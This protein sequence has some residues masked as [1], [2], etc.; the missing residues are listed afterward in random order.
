MGAGLTFNYN[1]SV[2]S[3][4]GGGGAV[5]QVTGSGAGISVT[6]STGNVVITNTGVTALTAGSGISLTASTGAV[7]ISA[8]GGGSGTVTQIIAA[9]PLTGGTISTV[10][11]I[12]LGT[13][14]VIPGPYTNAN[15]V[16]DAYGRITAA[17]NGTPGGGGTVTSVQTGTGLT[18]GPIFNSGTICLANTAVTPGA[19]NSA[20]ITIDQQGRI[21]SASSG[22][23][24]T[25]TCVGTGTGLTGGAF[26]TA[27]TIALA[28]TTVNPGPY[29]N[30][31]IT[32]DQQGRITAASNGTAGTVTSIATG[33]G[34]TGG[35]ITGSGTLALANTT[36][37]PDTY[38]LATITVD[39]QGRIT[40]A[41]N[42]TAPITAISG[43]GAINVSPGTTP[44][45]SIDSA[46]TTALGAVQ[47]YDGTNSSS[48]T[49]A[50]T[51]AQGQCLQT[52]ISTLLTTP[53][54]DLAGTVNA[55]SGDV[56][57]VTS[58]GT[59]AGYTVGDPL[60]AADATT[61]NTYV[62]VT[63]AGTLT[64]PGGSATVATVGDWFLASETSPGVYAWQ[65][66]NVGFDAPAATTT[67]AGIACLSTNALAQAGTDTTT[68]LTPAAAA[69]AFIPNSA[70]TGKGSILGASG[71]GAPSALPVGTDGQMLVACSSA[72]SGLCWTS[73]SI[74]AIPCATITG[75]G[76]IVTGT[77]SSAP[78]GLSVGSDG[79][80]LVACN[81]AATGLCWVSQ[82]SAAIPCSVLN[83]KG[84]LITTSAPNTPIAL[85]PGTDGQML[86]ACNSAF[87]GL[88]WI[89]Q[90]AAAIPCSVLNVKGALITTSTPD[91]PVA[92]SPGTNGQV[93]AACSTCPE[94]LTWVSP[95]V[96]PVATP[97]ITGTVLG[98]T[99]ATNAALGCNALVGT[100]SGVNN[101]GI[102]LNA[103]CSNATGCDNVYVGRD[104]GC[105]VTGDFNT[106]VG[107]IALCAAGAAG[108]CA[109]VAVGSGA[110]RAATG[111][112]GS[113][114]T[115]IGT[116]AGCCITTG[117]FNT[118]LGIS[119]GSN[120]TTGFTNVAIGSF[121]HV[122]DGTASCQL[123]IGFAIGC[124]W[125]TGNSTKAIQPGA[126]II[127]CAGSCGTAGQVLMS[128]GANAICWG[129][130]GGGSGTVTSITAGPGLTGGT[131]TTSG[132][133][134]LDTT[135]VIS[136]SVV[137]AKGTIVTGTAPNTPSGLGVGTDGQ[138]LT[139]CAACTTGLTWAAAG[140]GGASPATPTVAGIVLGCTTATNSALG[141]NALAAT[142]TGNFNT[143]MG[144]N[145]GCSNT[146]GSG[147]IYIGQDAAVAQT[148]GSY[149]T[150][151]G[152]IGMCS[153]TSVN[154][155]DAVA[156]GAG[157]LRRV[158][159]TGGSST[160]A[161]GTNSGC[162][163]TTG[164]FN[165]FLGNWAGRNVTTG[166][167]NVAIG[168]NV[169]VADPT[170]SCQ[171][172]I[173]YFT[174]A[175]WLTGNSTKAIKP[176]AGII[177]S[178]DSCGTTGQYL[179]SL[180]N[181]IRWSA[182]SPS[183]V[184]DKE[185]LGPVPTALPVI[186]EIETITY[187]WKDRETNE[188]QDEVIY[189]FS[190]QQLRGV[191][192]LL[193]DA[194]DEENLRIHDRKIVPLL[195]KAVQELS[196]KVEALEAKLA[197]NG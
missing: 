103:G 108:V 125:L 174:G 41:S 73:Q 129:T 32:V 35:T 52:Q 171:L 63:T 80:V 77:A 115:A 159:G 12:G 181:A 49:L 143:A 195:V 137:T 127:D 138:V 149:N 105:S 40:A 15:I 57:S 163:V 112:G 154:P 197:D 152:S 133:V 110:L 100:T 86:V 135:C 72:I 140:G 99:T 67:T 55:S 2:V 111:L 132:T 10:G 7:Q 3:A 113:S 146:T 183:D 60:P 184:R 14:A 58:I 119:A 122:A 124:N 26:T 97:T 162:N 175:N 179:W 177:D 117:T 136:P 91:T 74:A 76:T 185:V 190:A 59:T 188:T 23:V 161:I 94:G 96:T 19:Y 71:P 66:L 87:S 173:G 120:I 139:A 158:S 128:N 160:T 121:V 39:Q 16:V 130:V 36:V 37:N 6:P 134:A 191:D 180:G 64:P 24:G 34:L 18:G 8:T 196:A 33:T 46:S 176:G 61:V 38:T 53:N 118:L 167:S 116:N 95:S 144:L 186:T 169:T 70:L 150:I 82:P 31:N 141:C 102:G 106:V 156:I 65:F 83:V 85:S 11:T 114:T 56:D 54:I 189:G 151:I 27:G 84:A 79:Q 81:A 157:A 90:P 101:V 153:A 92:L 5:N 147:N 75:K 126:G 89:N 88:C 148:A 62:I 50:L 29:T 21:T 164:T 43:T 17:N 13:T 168:P 170:V 1:A 109:A 145:A 104:S 178:A 68:A 172:A 51:A 194:E 47:L 30:A 142:T 48:T 4:S 165:T 25:V 155:F 42:G 28:D 45:V 166:S 78:A 9:A 107:S 131:I 69:S 20:N 187:K 192:P 98:C 182:S 93:L 44:V 22:A 193:V 123:A